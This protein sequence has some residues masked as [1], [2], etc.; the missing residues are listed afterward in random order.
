VK[1]DCNRLTGSGATVTTAD[2]NSVIGDCIVLRTRA[3]A[4]ACARKVRFVATVA[5]ALT[6]NI[7]GAP[8]DFSW[9]TRPRTHV[10]APMDSLVISPTATAHIVFL[11]GT[12]ASRQA[13]KCSAMN[14]L[15]GDET[16]SLCPTGTSR[17][18]SPPQASGPQ[19]ALCRSKLPALLKKVMWPE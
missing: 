8:F 16:I 7:V 15:C 14:L 10:M 12:V 1:P 9:P 11:H 2:V 13:S 6:T 17:T 18:V 3:K 19:C 5:I 4:A